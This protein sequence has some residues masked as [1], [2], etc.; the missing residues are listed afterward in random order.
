MQDE[1]K[2]RLEDA[3]RSTDVHEMADWVLSDRRRLGA[4]MEI[5]TGDD[6]KWTVRA[7]RV[8]GFCLDR[9]LSRLAAH[10]EAL[11]DAIERPGVHPSLTR[12]VFRALESA[13]VPGHLEGRILR[14]AFAAL[15]GTAGIAAQ[16][17]A[18]TVL[19]RF[20]VNH[21]EV[22][23][24]AR[25]W[26]REILPEASAAVRSRARRDFGISWRD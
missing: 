10:L 16:A 18:I 19:K 22:L 15:S 4:L 7:T 24:E 23:A 25:G 1:I 8:A 26:V 5:I 2:H 13:P 6:G 11:L 9:D 12:M 3:I 14:A 21:P 20:A 17:Y